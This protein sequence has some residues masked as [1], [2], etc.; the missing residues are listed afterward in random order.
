MRAAG[1]LHSHFHDLSVPIC[2]LRDACLL[3]LVE[4]EAQQ[5]APLQ[6]ICLQILEQLLFAPLQIRLPIPQLQLDH[7]LLPTEIDDDIRP[8][9]V[10]GLG[11]YIIVPRTVIS[12]KY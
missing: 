10:P 12:S 5:I 11:F 4:A 8:G 2:Y 6:A 7:E 3:V 9:F 1:V